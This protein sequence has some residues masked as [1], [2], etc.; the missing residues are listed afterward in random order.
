MSYYDVLVFAYHSI[1]FKTQLS[2]M[3]LPFSGGVLE[4]IEL[5]FKLDCSGVEPSEEACAKSP[6]KA[7]QFKC[8]PITISMKIQNH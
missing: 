7:I 4:S 6:G 1:L 8:F 3:F 2:I 5:G